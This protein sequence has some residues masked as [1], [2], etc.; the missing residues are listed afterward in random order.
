MSDYL[1]FCI[2]V[3]LYSVYHCF[4][5]FLVKKIYMGLLNSIIIHTCMI[6]RVCNLCTCECVSVRARV[7]CGG[8]G[9]GR[10]V[11]LCSCACVRG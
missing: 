5:F 1:V 8:G 2:P 3:S 11:G 9:G 7:C 6:V 10:H 4:F